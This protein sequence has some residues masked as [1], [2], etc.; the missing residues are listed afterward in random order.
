MCRIWHVDGSQ[1][2]VGMQ[3]NILAMPKYFPGVICK[4]CLVAYWEEDHYCLLVRVL[5]AAYQYCIDGWEEPSGC[6]LSRRAW[7]LIGEGLVRSR[8]LMYWRVGR[9]FWLLIGEKIL[10]VSWEGSWDGVTH[11]SATGFPGQGLTMGSRVTLWSGV[12]M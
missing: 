5:H 4:W 7:L 10:I 6:L 8:S 3:W 2:I 1:Y 12:F 9:A 11:Q